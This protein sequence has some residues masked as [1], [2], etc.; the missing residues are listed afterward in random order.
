M[1]HSGYYI[2]LMSGTSADGVDLA[3]VSFNEKNVELISHYYQAYNQALAQKIIELYSPSINEIDRLGQLS[4]ELAHFFAQAIQELLA[5][6][7]MSPKDI[8][9]IGCHGQTI[10]H[11][12]AKSEYIN[13]PFT[14]QIGCSQ[15][16]ACLTGIRTIGDFRTKDMALGGQGAP[17]VPAFHRYLFNE[18]QQDAF[19][20][21]L[22]GIA[23]IT[24]LP[25]D[26]QQSVL[27]FDTGPAN[28]LLDAW[29]L[30][31]TGKSF[32]QDGNWGAQGAISQPLLTELLSD[33]YFA[34]PA[35]KSTGREYFTLDWLSQYL[36][37]YNLAAVDVQATLVAL[38]AHSVANAINK[39]SPKA[40]VYLCGGGIHNKQCY[41]QLKQQLS[42]H[43][44]NSINT[45]KLNNNAFEAMAF[46]WLAFAYDKKFYGN[47]PTVT[48]ASK[49]TVL[50]IEY[51]S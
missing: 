16:L 29:C 12:P 50:G 15:T 8:I 36:S 10:R 26:K 32:D 14:L 1:S 48:G 40:F 11:R 37:C 49:Q 42:C 28:A 33:P 19:I 21:N 30:Q 25:E 46:A 6:Q 38:T 41:K 20:V 43:T 9:A 47:I 13:Y 39:L 24:Y 18:L 34:L 31:H 7:K 5:Q 23:N 3:L 17:L 22:G 35:P 27:G 51:T 2:G 4:V 45:L 44:L